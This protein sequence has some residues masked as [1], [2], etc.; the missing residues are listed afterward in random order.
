MINKGVLT[1]ERPVMYI[2]I[3]DIVQGFE[4]S[5]VFSWEERLGSSGNKATEV[6]RDSVQLDYL[7]GRLR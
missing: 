5:E 4:V 6:I 3:D 2:T 7:L 1:L